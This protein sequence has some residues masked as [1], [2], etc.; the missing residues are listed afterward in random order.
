VR[1][2]LENTAPEIAADIIEGGIV[3]TGG[4]S[5]LAGIDRLLAIETGL[6][7]KVAENP[8]NCV[9]FGAGRALE[10]AAYQGV[11]HAA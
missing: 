6:P 2:A 11:L 9:A 10:D 5:L 7:V 8:L 1:S 3:M 4:G